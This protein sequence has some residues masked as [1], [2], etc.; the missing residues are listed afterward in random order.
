MIALFFQYFG[1][2]FL[3]LLNVQDYAMTFCGGVLLVI[4]SLGMIFPTREEV[5]V[6]GLKREPFIVPIATPLLS[7][8]GVLT[9]IM[10]SSR[11]LNNH[12]LLSAAILIA[13]AGV[14]LVMISAPYLQKILGNRGM[15]ILEQLM[16]MMLAMIS[17]QMLVHGTELYLK[18]LR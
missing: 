17:I 7:G 13:W 6:E 11:Q 12:L 10:L 18:V 16:G 3:D 14:I 5:H 1:E 9:L 15:I 2:L 8:P 4:I